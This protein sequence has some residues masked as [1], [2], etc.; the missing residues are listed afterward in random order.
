[1]L[2]E[3][4]LKEFLDRTADR[5]T[6]PGGGCVAALAGAA[7]AAL[8]EMVAAFTRGRPRFAAVA[9]RIQEIAREAAERR[10]RLTDAVDR[11][12]EAY[13]QVMAAH[14]LPA[15]EAAASEARR[16]A[17]EAALHEATLVPLDV[18]KAAVE[19]L[20]LAL[21]AMRIGNP[22]LVT[23]GLVAARMAHAAAL[24]AL[25]NAH[26]NIA[27]L[28]DRVFVIQTEKIAA[29]LSERAEALASATR[30]AAAR[31]DRAVPE[32]PD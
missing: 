32:P 19:V 21:Q 25:D 17:L 11:D 23:D 9:E 22:Q 27:D 13:R 6:L 8:V 28:T 14:R 5:Q 7:A 15:A 12:A 16:K 26:F 2:T 31:I 18:A 1:M 3:H 4:T 24:S 20:D 30:Q 10:R 29:H